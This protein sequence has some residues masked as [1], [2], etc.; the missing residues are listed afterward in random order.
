MVLEQRIRINPEKCTGCRVCELICSATKHN[1]FNPKRSRIHIVKMERFFIDIPLVCRMC[2]NPLCVGSCPTAAIKK[3]GNGTVHIDEKLCTSCQKCVEACP[4]G[5]IS[6]DSFNNKAIV[7]DLCAGDPQCV[8]WCPAGA[9]ELAQNQELSQRKNWKTVE[10]TAK[11]LIK[12]WKIPL[13]EYERYY[14][15]RRSKDV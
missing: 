2:P 9:L 1:E 4:F 12:K 10:K 14:G 15:K 8:S 11:S 6:I 3:E 7:C 13:D 5:A